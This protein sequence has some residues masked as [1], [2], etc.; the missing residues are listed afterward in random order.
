MKKFIVVIFIFLTFASS[1]GQELT[2]TQKEKLS[3]FGLEYEQLLQDNPDNGNGLIQILEK[4]HKHKKNKTVG[5]VLGGLG[6][7]TTVGG[8]LIMA[9]ENPENGL[10]RKIVGVG[11]SVLG[12]IEMGVSISLFSSSRKR[13]KER[14]KMI[15]KLNPEWE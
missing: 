5:I 6:F 9:K 7:A 12:A 3:E 11:I 15:I 2:N 10:S 1:L 8:I 4:N 14:D 13:K